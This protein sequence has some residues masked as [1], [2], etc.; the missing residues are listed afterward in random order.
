MQGG[1]KL[2]NVYFGL[3][4]KVAFYVCTHKVHTTALPSRILALESCRAPFS[5]AHNH[6]E[7]CYECTEL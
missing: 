4:S 6:L 5:D 1:I 3:Q 7:S 2:Q